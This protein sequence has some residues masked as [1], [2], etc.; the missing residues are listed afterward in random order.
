MLIGALHFHNIN[1]YYILIKV[2]YGY[3]TLKDA[4]QLIYAIRLGRFL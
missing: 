2:I 3:L 1:K 4:T